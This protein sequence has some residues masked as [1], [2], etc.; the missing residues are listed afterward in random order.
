MLSGNACI[1]GPLIT[2]A[3]WVTL[4]CHAVVI[5]IQNPESTCETVH[6]KTAL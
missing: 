6:V 1:L 3:V 4:T 5:T 2:E